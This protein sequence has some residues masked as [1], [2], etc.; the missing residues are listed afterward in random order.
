MTTGFTA[1]IAVTIFA[2]QLKD[3]FGLTIL[4]EEGGPATIPAEFV[5]KL[6]VLFDHM[7]TINWHATGV[8][9]GSLAVLILF[10]ACC[11]GCRGR[12][13]R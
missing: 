4:N 7:N 5:P 6:G 8:G 11:R 3:F 12:S 2:S 10:S 13:L 9:V 1:G